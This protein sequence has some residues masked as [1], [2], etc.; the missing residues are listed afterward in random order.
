MAGQIISSFQGTEGQADAF[1]LSRGTI[2]NI[3]GFK[4]REDVLDFK[5]ATGYAYPVTQNGVD[6]LAIFPKKRTPN[7]SA[8]ELFADGVLFV[9]GVTFEQLSA[10]NINGTLINVDDETQKL[11]GTA[12]GTPVPAETT[13]NTNVGIMFGA[14]GSDSFA[15]TPGTLNIVNG[16]D[17]KEDKITA[18]G[19][20]YYS[21]IETD[22]YSGTVILAKKLAPT[23]TAAEIRAA[24]G[25]LLVNVTPDQLTDVNISGGKLIEYDEASAAE[26]TT[27]A[28]ADTNSSTTPSTDAT[29]I[30][31]NATA[32]M[33]TK[34]T[35]TASATATMDVITNPGTRF[36]S[37]RAD[38]VALNGSSGSNTT[39]P[40]MNLRGGDD[41]LSVSNIPNGTFMLGS[42]KDSF[43]IEGAAGG[44]LNIMAGDAGRKTGLISGAGTINVLAN[45]YDISIADDFSGKLMVSS[46]NRNSTLDINNADTT[47][48][49]VNLQNGL[50]QADIQFAAGGDVSVL[51]QSNQKADFEATVL[52]S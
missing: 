22:E 26:P 46:W 31:A 7:I 39:S 4:P 1:S 16:F 35:A 25:L 45:D 32:T 12:T 33:D 6:Y 29:T 43:N 14:S 15:L 10:A 5:G 2:N 27:T 3:N 38:S 51:L 18:L 48:K 19:D 21:P 11:T 37:V 23:A 36:G 49:Y 41:T 50:I 8:T 34:T 30:G 20:V 17:P 44:V 13:T 40:F 47:I 9:A 24:G 42:G 28:A 52:A